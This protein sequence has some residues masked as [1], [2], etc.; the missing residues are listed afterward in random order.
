MS[1]RQARPKRTDNRSI[2]PE[3]CENLYH[4]LRKLPFIDS[5]YLNMQA[6][7]IGVTDLSLMDMERQLLTL[8]IEIERTPTLEAITVSAWSQMWIFA[9]YELLRTWRQLAREVIE[10]GKRLQS[11]Q[12]NERARIV[13]E[14]QAKLTKAASLAIDKG[15]F[16]HEPFRAVEDDPTSAAI[17][18]KAFELTEPLFRVVEATRV[19]LAK[20]EV[21]KSGGMLANAPGYGR[22]DMSDGSIYWMISLRDRT[23]QIV[24]RRSVADACRGLSGLLDELQMSRQLATREH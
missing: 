1:K 22:I 5:L 10:Y 7:N 14:K 2:G 18:E 24:S 13:A 20:H 4:V 12:T 8:Y 16:H 15:A 17:I 21:P 3:P 19:T 9:F 23:D 6:M 11:A